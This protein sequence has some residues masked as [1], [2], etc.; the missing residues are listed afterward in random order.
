M[1]TKTIKE[2][3]FET[4][5]STVLDYV[6][7]QYE[8]NRRLLSSSIRNK[9]RESKEVI[10]P[11]DKGLEK[12]P[13]VKF[14]DK[15]TFVLGVAL[16]VLSEYIILARPELMHIFYLL[17]IIPLVTS[18]YLVYR[19]NGWHYFLLDF[20]YYTNALMIIMVISVFM[21]NYVTPLFEICFVLANGP[22]LLAIPLWTNSLVFHDLTKLTSISI[23]FLPAM[24]TYTIRWFSDVPVEPSLTFTT[25]FLYPILFYCFW[26]ATYLIITEVFKR[27]V[28]YDEGYMTSIR[29]LTHFKPHKLY[30]IIIEK[31]LLMVLTQLVYTIITVLPTFL[32][33]KF[34]V[35]QTIWMLFCFFWSAWNGANF[36]FEIFLYKYQTYLDR[37]QNI[38]N[39]KADSSSTN[40]VSEKKVDVVGDTPTDMK[41]D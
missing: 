26:Q 28:I 35:L 37:F 15:I 6:T 41:T 7:L 27:D 18:R 38:D 32:Y 9:L 5:D 31:I 36:Y 14:L 29:W 24:V 16:L 12:Q 19:M 10:A 23:H 3:S 8:M 22:L 17:V 39:P 11:I 21:F 30:Y 40:A 4:D 1:S 13:N 34:R 33:Y 25:G 2:E 20:C